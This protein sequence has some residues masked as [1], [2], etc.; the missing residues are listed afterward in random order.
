MLLNRLVEIENRLAILRARA[1]KNNFKVSDCLYF[2]KGNKNDSIMSPREIGN[3]PVHIKKMFKSQEYLIEANLNSMRGLDVT[4]TPLILNGKSITRTFTQVEL[5]ENLGKNDPHEIIDKLVLND[6]KIEIKHIPVMR[7]NSPFKKNVQTDSYKYPTIFQTC[8]FFESKNYQI[9]VLLISKNPDRIS[10]DDT[11]MININ[12]MITKELIQQIPIEVKTACQKTG[13]KLNLIDAIAVKLT[14]F[15][16]LTD[17]KFSIDW[18]HK[19]VDKIHALIRVQAMIRGVLARVNK[20][21]AEA[22][23]KKSKSS[24]SSATDRQRSK[25]SS[26]IG[27]TRREKQAALDLSNMS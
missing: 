11:L 16:K 9:K 12:I 23:T 14:K 24:L 22:L 10:N 7:I 19:R 20:T 27:S 5:I 6:G 18:S 13:M 3:W 15:I 17:G 26:I 1:P 2:T 8:K 25:T 4:F 21:K